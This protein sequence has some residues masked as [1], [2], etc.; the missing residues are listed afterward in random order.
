MNNYQH[1]DL[2]SGRWGELTFFQ[3][4]GNIGSEVVRAI[5]WKNKGKK[6][7]FLLAFERALELFDLTIEDSKNIKRLKEIT[8]GRELFADY[9]VCD[10][11]YKSDD[12]FFQ[13]Y[14]YQF[15]Y[16]ANIGK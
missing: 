6:D 1:K 5:K 14:F 11:I 9:M 8:R 15:S 16:A 3:Q 2:A 13:N 4:M 7:Y 12:K 10:N